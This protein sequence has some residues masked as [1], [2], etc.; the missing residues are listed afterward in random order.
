MAK[1]TLEDGTIINF[2][3]NPTQEEIQEAADQVFGRKEV[4]RREAERIG[5]PEIAGKLEREGFARERPSL[6]ERV[7]GK[8]G[9]FAP[10]IGQTVGGII[11]SLLGLRVKAPK[12]GQ[13]IGGTAGRAGGIALQRLIRGQGANLTETEK[14]NIGKELIGTAAIESVLAPISA[15]L[16][17][18]GR[19]ALESLLGPRVAE[20]GLKQGFKRFL[21]PKF[22]QDRVPKQVVEKTSKF[23]DKL[24][25]VTGEGVSKAV[26]SKSNI[27][28]GTKAIKTEAQEALSRQSA[29]SIDDLGSAVVSKAQLNKVKAARKFIDDLPDNANIP[30][31]WNARKEIDKI[32]FRF[33]F[34]PEIERYLDDLRIS[35]NDPIKKSG[36]DVARAFG[37]YSSVKEMEKQLGNKFRATLIDDEIFSP[38]TEQFANTLLGTSK[39][40]T[41]RG[42]QK[43]DSFLKAGDRVAE[44]LLDVAATESLGKTIQFMGVLQ[45][46]VIGGLGGQKGIAGVAAATQSPGGQAVRTLINRGTALGGTE[47]LSDG[48]TRQEDLQR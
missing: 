48:A 41:V 11:G 3:G 46:S 14:K 7:K 36:D 21:D 20:R 40:E 12:R 38:N 30:R 18:A 25:R 16:G 47:L 1:V 35:L 13:A 39:D 37:R 43:L 32:R 26:K 19:G 9:A 28:V 6:P 8:V 44:D 31:L 34:D 42:I 29:A 17:G 24:N 2:E 4:A 10:E 15:A 45:R 27:I 5:Q 23:F 33:K 22:Y